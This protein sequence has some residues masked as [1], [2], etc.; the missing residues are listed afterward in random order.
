MANHKLTTLPSVSSGQEESSRAPAR[1]IST[2]SKKRLTPNHFDLM[3]DWLE[4]DGNYKRIF[5]TTGKDVIGKDTDSCCK[6]FKK[7]ACHTNLAGD[8][9]LTALSLRAEFGRYLTKYKTIKLDERLISVGLTEKEYRDDVAFVAKRYEKN[10]PRFARMD[11]IFVKEPTIL[12]LDSIKSSVN[13]RLEVHG[14]EVE[15]MEGY[16]EETVLR[17]DDNDHQGERVNAPPQDE[18][19]HQEDNPL[20]QGAKELLDVARQG[21][22]VS[23][24]RAA[25]AGAKRAKTEETCQPPSKP[26]V[27]LLQPEGSSFASAYLEGVFFQLPPTPQ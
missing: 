20:D 16:D 7:W 6:S 14:A 27:E 21:K 25:P 2:G 15:Q 26:N 22:R 24:T 1:A 10:C 13:G 11:K 9:Q 5:E 17:N 8:P 3:L 12:V 18:L 4:R 23:V 19:A